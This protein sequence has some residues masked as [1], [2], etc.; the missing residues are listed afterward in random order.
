MA[1]ST[2]KQYKKKKVYRYKK[3][4]RSSAKSVDLVEGERIETKVNRLIHNKEPI[5]DG[6]PMIYTEKSDGVIAAYNIRSDRWE[7]ATE[8]MDK[9]N[10]QR[11]AEGSHNPNVSGED[12]NGNVSSGDE[13][14]SGTESA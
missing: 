9:V 10:A 6:A 4:L 7:L 5:K 12:G 11:I 3:P 13:S 8:A 14:I 2:Y 1:K